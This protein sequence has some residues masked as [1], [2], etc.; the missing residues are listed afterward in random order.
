MYDRGFGKRNNKRIKRR[1][2]NFLNVHDFDQHINI[3]LR[4]SA[5]PK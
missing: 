1:S 4:S 5:N 2:R 3:N